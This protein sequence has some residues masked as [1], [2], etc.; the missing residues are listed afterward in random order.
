[1]VTRSYGAVHPYENF[2]VDDPYAVVP[3]NVSQTDRLKLRGELPLQTRIYSQLHHGDTRNL[4]R[5]T[6]RRFYGFDVRLS[7]SYFSRMTLDG[8]VRYNRQLNQLPPFL[9]P[10]EDIARVSVPTAIIPPYGLRHPVDYLR[11]STGMNA[12]WRPFYTSGLADQLTFNA[13]A[14]LGVIDRSYA[15]YQVQNPPGFRSQAR[16]AFATYFAGT[17]MRW[18]PR[19]DTRLRYEHRNASNPLFGVTTYLGLT[20]TN[21]PS[22]QDI[23]RLD[24][25]WLA[26]DNLMATTSVSLENRQNHT[27]VAD[28]VEDDFPMTFT[29]WY[30]P[31]PAWSISGGYGFYSNWIDQEIYFPSDTPDAQPFDRRQWNYG[32]RGQILSLGANYAHTK[33]LT[34][35]GGLQWVWA[36]DAFDPLLPWPDLPG[37]SE[38]RVNTRRYVSGVDWWGSERLSAYLRYIYEDYDDASAPYYSGSAHMLL[39]GLTGTR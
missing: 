3:E 35:S 8:F 36:F 29:F 21:Q 28:F 18:H 39:A 13:G 30:A 34:F 2:A 37:Y 7:N 25:T 6:R 14:E 38:V 22:C 16:T 5:D 10:P 1:M 9:V 23:V 11:T 17:T 27:S 12:N 20:S 19:F 26:A 24:T 15:E 33:R 31:Q 4:Q 32:G